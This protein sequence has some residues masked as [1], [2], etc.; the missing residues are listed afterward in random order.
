MS[1]PTV[2]V[3]IRQAL[4]TGQRRAAELGRTQQLE[5]GEDLFIRIAPGGR[6]FLLF[7]LAEEPDDRTA[8]AVAE[9]LG[10]RN[11]HYGWYQGATLRS[12][13]AAEEGESLPEHREPQ[14]RPEP[15]LT[16]NTE[17]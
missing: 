10:L 8:R 2:T 12:L 4:L 1:H 17:S 9:A 5:L 15:A 13:M 7:G 14:G 6:R 16:E 3:S 11:P